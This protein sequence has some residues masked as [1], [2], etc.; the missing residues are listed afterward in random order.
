MK[1]IRIP[2]AA[3]ADP[4]TITGVNKRVFAEHGVDFVKHDATHEDD[5]T[6]GVRIVKVR[7]RKLFG[8]WSRRG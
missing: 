4:Q 6:R 2:H 7:T 1:E 5:H 3:I 8:P